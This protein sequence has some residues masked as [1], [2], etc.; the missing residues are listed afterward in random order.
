M[1]GERTQYNNVVKQRRPCERRCCHHTKKY[2][3]KFIR[4]YEEDLI[5]IA[6]K[7]KQP[8]LWPS[9]RQTGNIRPMLYD[10]ILFSS[11]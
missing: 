2:I 4:F 3:K 10:L 8:L 9:L 7:Q 1:R 5:I 11:S 6:R